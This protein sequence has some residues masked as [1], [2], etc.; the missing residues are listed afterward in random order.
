MIIKQQTKPPQLNLLEHLIV[1]HSSLDDSDHSEY[2]R[3]QKG[4]L[5]EIEFA[6]FLQ[7][8][9][10]EWLLFHDLLLEKD[11]SVFQIDSLVISP[12]KIYLFEVKNY[13]GDFIFSQDR[14]YS[15]NNL[16]IQNPLDQVK[17]SETFL[18]QWFQ[19]NKLHHPPIT[20]YVIFIN[21][22]FYLYHSH[23]NSS[24]FIFYS[25][26]ERLLTKIQK[27]TKTMASFHTKL[28]KQLLASHLD[29]NPYT[30][31]PEYQYE[32]LNKGIV[33]KG[34]R[35]LNTFFKGKSIHCT[36]CL[37][38]EKLNQAV[39]R[40]THEF[41]LL[42]PDKKVTTYAIWDWCNIANTSK[43]S[44]RQILTTH[45]QRVDQTNNSYFIK[46]SL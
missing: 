42:F 34:C 35:S 12:E 41:M 23:Q 43:R 20:S 24:A 40:T 13:E 46:P 29:D 19:K 2:E 32:E 28:S 16:E 4:F 18:R 11:K 14:F 8:L 38:K 7:Q 37:T 6:Q 10:D 5:G 1:R 22:Q 27:Q 17:R 9:P 45:L 33:C 36:N 26:L 31:L 3:I 25:Q 15:I 21:P 44:I 39:I 30:R